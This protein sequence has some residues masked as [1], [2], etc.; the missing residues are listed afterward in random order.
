[1]EALQNNQTSKY[2]TKKYGKSSFFFN[3]S[4]SNLNM[5]GILILSNNWFFLSNNL[6]TNKRYIV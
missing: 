6:K 1:M 2:E 4:L 3:K 5:Y